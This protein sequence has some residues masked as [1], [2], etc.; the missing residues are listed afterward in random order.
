MRDFRRHFKST[1]LFAITLASLLISSVAQ[2]YLGHVESGANVDFFDYYFAAQ[3]VRD[4]PHANLYEGATGTNPQL[5]SAPAGSEI[6]A[7]ARAA[8]F[9][10]IELYLY[11]P[12]LADILR[13][14]SG[15][16]AHLAA[17]LW[18]VFNLALVLVSVILIAHMMRVPILSFEFSVLALAAYSFWPIHETV[19]D[20]QISIVMLALWAVGIVAYCDDCIVLS[21]A[22]FALATAFKITPILILPLFFIWKDRKWLV[23]F[24]AFLLGL[25]LAMATINGLPMVKT[26]AAVMSAMGDGAPAMQ[27]KSLSSLVA[28][29]Y[30]GRLFSLLSVHEILTNPPRALLIAE[31]TISGSF[32]L[33]SLWP[34]WRSRHQLGL[35]SKAA[36]IAIFGLITACVSPVSWRHSYSVAFIALAV[37]WIRSLRTKPRAL[38][39]AL[40][41]LTTFTLGS[42][43]FDLVVQAPLP[44]IG[45]VFFA[46]LWVVLSILFG[47][48]ALFHAGDDDLDSVRGDRHVALSLIAND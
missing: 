34:V 42:L 10:D 22:A 45:K 37:F 33:L 17:I 2:R 44:Q 28:W 24:L 18:R 26:Y 36:T 46:A 41:T 3:V 19:A 29:A 25:V 14:V 13:P 38:H 47:L 5:R 1:I 27:N 7:H 31:K 20:G 48:D 30:Y 35:S 40:L 8:G 12:L 4:N 43:F 15:L 6:F 21:A 23:A 11:P 9:D 32:Y 16:P 39:L